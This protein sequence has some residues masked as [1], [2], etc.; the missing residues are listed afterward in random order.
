MVKKSPIH[1]RTRM[2]RT[3]KRYRGG[4]AA[5]VWIFDL[6]SLES[7]NITDNIANDELP[8]WS[9][10]KIYYLSDKG[11]EARFNLW[12]YDIK[13]GT[14]RANHFLQRL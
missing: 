7:K 3:W 2:F 8:M 4:T 10:E 13:S 12:V 6:E 1:D 9:G 11:P 14:K 5:D